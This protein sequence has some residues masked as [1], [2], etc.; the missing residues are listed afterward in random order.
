MGDHI[1][2]NSINFFARAGICEKQD[3]GLIRSVAKLSV[4]TSKSVN[5]N[6]GWR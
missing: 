1:S 6:R 2:N 3:N 5:C 4:K